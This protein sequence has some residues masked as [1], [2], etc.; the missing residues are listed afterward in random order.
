VSQPYYTDQDSDNEIVEQLAALRALPKETRRDLAQF[1]T[2]DDEPATQQG[3]ARTGP[4]TS[5]NAGQETP[6]VSNSDHK[7]SAAVL[8]SY[9]QG[10]YGDVPADARRD[11]IE[12]KLLEAGSFSDGAA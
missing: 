11:F 2:D 8:E 12:A 4:A 1:L 7:S 9:R 10:K 5:A 6:A 3:G